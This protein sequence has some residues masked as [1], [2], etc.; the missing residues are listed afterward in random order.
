[1]TTDRAAPTAPKVAIEDDTTVTGNANSPDTQR[2]RGHGVLDTSPIRARLEA[3]TGGSWFAFRDNNGGGT[4]ILIAAKL[5][6]GPD[7]FD[8]A[9]CEVCAVDGAN[10]D[11][12]MV[13]GWGN[14]VNLAN[15]EFIA[16]SPDDVRDLLAEVDRLH[17]EVARAWDA[18]HTAGA[19][20]EAAWDGWR[21]AHGH[22]T[23]NPYTTSQ[24]TS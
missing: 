3:A 21:Y 22:P 2:P 19:G 11:A 14:G 24:V 12:G 20:D 17:G 7:A 5:N 6:A 18:G 8:A 1:M 4:E 9:T 15:A 23:P 16:H 10:E 13:L